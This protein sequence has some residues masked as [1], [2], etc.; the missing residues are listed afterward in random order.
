MN[1]MNGTERYPCSSLEYTR[2]GIYDNLYSQN[3][4]KVLYVA[5][6]ADINFSELSRLACGFKFS[7]PVSHPRKQHK[8]KPKQNT[9]GLPFSIFTRT[10]V[11]LRCRRVKIIPQLINLFKNAREF[12]VQY[13]DHDANVIDITQFLTECHGK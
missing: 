3:T 2:R 4:G 7:S 5:C 10:C 13:L 9:M 11:T 6:N 1:S 12:V 8:H